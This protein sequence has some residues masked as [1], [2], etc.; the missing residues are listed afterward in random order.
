MTLPEQDK[1]P[2]DTRFT[3]DEIETEPR[4][5]ANL[6]TIFLVFFID[7]TTFLMIFP[8]KH[9]LLPQRFLLRCKQSTRKKIKSQCQTEKYANMNASTGSIETQGLIVKKSV[10]MSQQNMVFEG[11]RKMMSFLFYTTQAMGNLTKLIRKMMIRFIMHNS[12]YS[13]MIQHFINVN[14]TP[15]VTCQKGKNSF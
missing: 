12:C 5:G 3:R 11:P 8:L 13:N 4:D 1:T 10:Q 2:L 14:K 15:S 7:G 9:I 6:V